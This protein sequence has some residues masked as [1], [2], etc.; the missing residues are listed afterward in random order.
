[1]SDLAKATVSLDA[2]LRV[3][4]EAIAHRLDG[5][6]TASDHEVDFNDETGEARIYKRGR[7]ASRVSVCSV[8]L[9]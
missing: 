3:A 6:L 9:G 1:M 4:E 5:P 7:G 2:V 8:S